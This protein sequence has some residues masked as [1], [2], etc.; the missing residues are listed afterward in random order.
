MGWQSKGAA[1]PK[2]GGHEFLTVASSKSDRE[3]SNG[4]W[5]GYVE[6]VYTEWEIQN[7]VFTLNTEH[8]YEPCINGDTEYLN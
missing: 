7:N 1:S 5:H 8:M 2:T 6:H 4:I 3:L